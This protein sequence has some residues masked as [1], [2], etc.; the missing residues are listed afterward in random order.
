V[1][2]GLVDE[3]VPTLAEL[4]PAP[5]VWIKANPGA[6]T[7]PWTKGFK[8]PERRGRAQHHQIRRSRR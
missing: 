7:Q 2:Q 4:V 3:I 5:K 1:K 8:I 6:H